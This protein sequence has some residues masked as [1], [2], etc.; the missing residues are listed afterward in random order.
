[1]RGYGKTAMAIIDHEMPIL[2]FSGCEETFNPIFDKISPDN[3][4]QRV[5]PIIIIGV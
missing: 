5:W 4:R 3:L 2:D 1:M